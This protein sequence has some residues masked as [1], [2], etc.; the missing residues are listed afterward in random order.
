MEIPVRY[1]TLRKPKDEYSSVR[2]LSERVVRQEL[3]KRGYLT[4]RGFLLD[5]FFELDTSGFVWWALVRQVGVRGCIRIAKYCA[6]HHGTPDFLA[7]HAGRGVL[8]VEVK[9]GNERIM[10]HQLLTMER[11]CAWGVP[12][13]VWRV[14][15][16]R[17]KVREK[18]IDLSS[19]LDNGDLRDATDKVSFE[20]AVTVYGKRK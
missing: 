12:C 1:L 4:V 10:P 2:A 11:L 16:R 9:L 7:A 6:R 19:Y 13:E 15:P 18:R 8:A 3:R 5:A 14:M 20:R 17:N